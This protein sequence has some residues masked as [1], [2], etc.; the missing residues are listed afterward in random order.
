M[1]R[2]ARRNY[3]VSPRLQKGM[4]LIELLVA[5]VISLIA[6]AG[7][8]AVM[9]N[10]LG[11][12]AQTIKL[13]KMTQEMR[14]AM[15]IMSRELRRANY[16]EG[17]MACYGNL[18]CLSDLGITNKISTIHITDNGDSDCFWFWYDRPGVSLANSPVAAFRRTTA[19]GV[20][21][22]QMTITQTGTPNCNLAQGWAAITDPELV[23]ITAFN[24][25]DAESIVE[26]VNSGGDTQSV[27]RI[28]LTI[29]A[30]LTPD[31][32]VPTWLQTGTNPNAARQLEEFISVRN[33][34][35]T[36]ASP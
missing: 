30:R 23:D 28:G 6:V 8:I 36:L 15:Q 29:T 20:G 3:P 34:T 11:T 24:V 1:L 5:G 32:S 7:M 22:L 21:V 13:T 18:D 17:F 12:G 25:S 4:T 9:A 33:H 31:T 2:I 35:T 10:T 26:T 16:H 19:N 27:E 14:T